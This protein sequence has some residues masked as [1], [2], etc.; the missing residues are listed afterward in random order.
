MISLRLKIR[1]MK[2]FDYLADIAIKIIM[3]KGFLLFLCLDKTNAL[4]TSFPNNKCDIYF[5]NQP[6]NVT[7]Y[8]S[9]KLFYATAVYTAISNGLFTM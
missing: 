7:F 8:P 9:N 3:D 5:H 2:I 1:I 6:E 4:N